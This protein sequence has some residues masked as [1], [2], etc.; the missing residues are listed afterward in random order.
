MEYAEQ[1]SGTIRL[2]L[3]RG[4][5]DIAQFTILMEHTVM[6]DDLSIHFGILG[7]SH[8]VRFEKGSEVLTEVCACTD[9]T[10]LPEEVIVSDF[11][12]NLHTLPVTAVFGSQSYSFSFT[13][14]PWKEGESR[15][16]TLREQ[17]EN[18]MMHHLTY[19]FPSPEEHP[20]EAVTELFL[21]L[22]KT[23]IFQSVHTYPNEGVM[24]FTESSFD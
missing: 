9:A 22:D 5:F 10:T 4:D 1:T 3:G 24:V 14:L 23:I 6:H 20:T 15:L 13:Y 12:P 2:Y 17:K 19:V 16:Q 11:L 7:E 21:T 8:Y 18:E